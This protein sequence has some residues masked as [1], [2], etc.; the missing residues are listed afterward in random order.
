MR[1]DHP[2]RKIRGALHRTVFAYEHAIALHRRF[3]FGAKTNDRRALKLTAE[4]VRQIE[5]GDLNVAA[6]ERFLLLM[7]RRIGQLN[8]FH[9][10]AVGLHLA[11]RQGVISPKHAE[12]VSIVGEG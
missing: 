10:K 7:A 4:K 12:T 2:A 1:T 5:I 9:I 11:R 8:D 6:D 3:P